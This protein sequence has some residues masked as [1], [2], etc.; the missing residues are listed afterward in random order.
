MRIVDPVNDGTAPD[1]SMLGGK[2]YSLARMSTAGFAVP[3]FVVITPQT[4]RE[5]VSASSLELDPFRDM[6]D[7]DADAVAAALGSHPIPEPARRALLA[8]V[9]AALGRWDS[10]AVRSS[11]NV[12][13]SNYSSFAGVFR[14]FLGMRDAHAIMQ[15]I[16]GCYASVF[17]AA[18]RKY[19]TGSTAASLRDLQMSVI[20]QEMVPAET[21]GILLT[22]DA[23]NLNHSLAIVNASYGLGDT[24]VQGDVTPDE[25]KVRKHD[26]NV[27]HRQLGPKDR[28]TRPADTREGG[29]ETYIPSAELS[30]RFALNSEE[31]GALVT[32][33]RELEEHFGFFQDVEWAIAQDGI[34]ILQSRPLTGTKLIYR[35]GK[36][37]SLEHS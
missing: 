8:E 4:Y 12:E 19:L 29:V 22:A 9:E 13:D 7:H 3:P 1:P 2:G 28:A 23:I 37:G 20:V 30:N 18:C 33:G 17:S 21:A 5:W 6:A 15:S 34:H 14:S 27:M 11:A 24:V 25:Y 36:R 32:V 31:L 10:V 16:V 26:G 35:S